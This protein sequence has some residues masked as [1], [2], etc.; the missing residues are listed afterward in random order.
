[1]PQPT[2]HDV[3]THAVNLRIRSDIRSLIDRAAVAYGKTRSDFMI[4]AARRAAEEALLDQSLVRVDQATYDHFL[5]VLDQPPSGEGF[6]RL[7]K[8][9]KPWAE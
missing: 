6:D 4:D 9:A 2:T 8:A 1:M 5:A 3:P 7:M